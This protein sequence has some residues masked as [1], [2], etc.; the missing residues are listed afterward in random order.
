MGVNK[1]SYLI[2]T[3][4]RLLLHIAS[5][6]FKLENRDLVNSNI[7]RDSDSDSDSDIEGSWSPSSLARVKRQVVLFKEMSKNW[8]QKKGNK[9]AVVVY[10]DSGEVF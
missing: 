8:L 3:L 2:N 9:A 1:Q 7:I 6:L 10:W 5:T 4:T